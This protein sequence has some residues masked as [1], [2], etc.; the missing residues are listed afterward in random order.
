MAELGAVL[1]TPLGPIGEGVG[2]LAGA[3]I[4]GIASSGIVSEAQ[5]KVKSLLGLDDSEQRAVN[6]QA[7]PTASTLGQLAPM[8]VTF[9]A[10]DLAEGIA[11]RLVT[12]GGMAGVDIAQQ[13]AEKGTV[14]PREAA[15]QGAAGFVL[16][17]SRGFIEP[18]AEAGAKVGQQI[19]GGVRKIF[20]AGRPDMDNPTKAADLK[21]ATPFR[22]TT[23]TNRGASTEQPPP[24]T[25]IPPSTLGDAKVQSSTYKSGDGGSEGV[26]AKAAP[27]SAE[28]TLTVTD[29]TKGRWW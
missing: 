9:K 15:L 19:G 21:T 27:P 4:A 5:E 28:A 14:D 22:A 29:G 13:Y 10:G 12:G 24:D 20:P 23:S 2:A 8:A 18:Y 1:G 17:K 11:Q 25:T 6:A 26:W 16:S 3:A 7:N